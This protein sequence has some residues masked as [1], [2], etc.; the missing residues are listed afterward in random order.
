MSNLDI[1]W[2]YELSYVSMHDVYTHIHAL[3]LVC[4]VQ[5]GEQKLTCD[6]KI[7]YLIS[8]VSLK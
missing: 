8:I 6:F 1:H 2:E 5:L 3:T 7:K 4:F